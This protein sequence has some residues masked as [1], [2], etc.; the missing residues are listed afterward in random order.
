MDES[1]GGGLQIRGVKQA[2]LVL[3][4]VFVGVLAIVVVEQMSAE[5]LAVVVGVIC[6]VAAAIPTSLLLWVVLTRSDRRRYEAEERR[7]RAAREP[8]PPVVVIQGGTP[9]ALPPGSEMDYWPAPGSWPPPGHVAERRWQ[10]VGGEE[11]LD[12]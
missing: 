10:I 12:A 4:A 8:Y 11:L 3:G 6:G 1:S 7:S 5:A 9:R 2:A